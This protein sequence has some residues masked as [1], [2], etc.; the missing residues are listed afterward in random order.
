MDRKWE[1]SA[2]RTWLNEALLDDISI[3]L[4]AD[5]DETGNYIETEDEVFLLSK[6]EAS[7][8]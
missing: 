4:A 1:T 2:A 5:R 8:S 3:N 6:A 7:K